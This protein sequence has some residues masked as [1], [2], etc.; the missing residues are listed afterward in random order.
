MLDR[1]FLHI[2]F[3]KTGSTA[4]QATL[5]EHSSMLARFGYFYPN[6]EENHH[7][8]V[9]AFH[10]D[11]RNW[12]FNEQSGRTTVRAVTEYRKAGLGC[13]ERLVAGKDGGTLVLSSEHLIDLNENS[14]NELR[15]YLESLAKSVHVVCYVRHP[16]AHALSAA[17]ERIKQGLE[18]L[19]EVLAQPRRY[20]PIRSE[21]GKWVNTFGRRRILLRDFEHSRTVEGDV[22]KDFLTVTG[23][24]E[25]AVTKI[26]TVQANQSLSYEAVLIASALQKSNPAL[27][28]G[29]GRL[30]YLSRIPGQPFTLPDWWLDGQLELAQSDL[31]YLREDFELEL[32]APSRPE[33]I[34]MSRLWGPATIR[35][36]AEG[37][38]LVSAH[39]DLQ[40]IRS[41]M[42]WKVTAPLRKS[43]DLM[44][45][46][47]N[48]A[49]RILKRR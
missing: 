45:R 19:E 1:C 11:P 34:D 13:L 4:I 39:A 42:S 38:S 36:V 22:V 44:G 17:Q 12:S 43:L 9:S 40:A 7:F 26:R 46:V 20:L 30:D 10:Q 21:L 31:S 47:S 24:A 33:S 27:S 49:Q 3:W 18:T 14:V 5:L 6:I 35:A 29:R 32:K 25:E 23:L 16:V 41:S 2:G 8:L 48:T 28:Q 15:D 37:L